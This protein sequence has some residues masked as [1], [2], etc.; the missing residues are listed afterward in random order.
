MRR[1]RSGM[2]GFMMPLLLNER[3]TV[4]L[5]ADLRVVLGRRGGAQENQHCV[6]MDVLPDRSDQALS[7][8]LALVGLING[9]ITEVTAIGEISDTPRNTHECIAAVGGQGQIA[10]LEHLLQS[11]GLI[12]GTPFAQRRAN[13][14]IAKLLHRQGVI[15]SN[16]DHVVHLPS[17][18]EPTTRKPR[19]SH[20][21]TQG[22]LYAA[23]PQEGKTAVIRA[24]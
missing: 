1:R 8:A 18:R 14:K 21:R 23:R 20:R 7:N 6:G 11:H 5:E 15:F 3:R 17:Y 19:R 16:L 4:T 22:L 10:L 12:D 2:A 9:K 13:E 24:R